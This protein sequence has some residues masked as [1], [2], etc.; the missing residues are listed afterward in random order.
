MPNPSTLTASE[1]FGTNSYPANGDTCATAQRQSDGIGACPS[2]A[3]RAVGD[4]LPHRLTDSTPAQWD[5]LEARA[6]ACMRAQLVRYHLHGGMDNAA[7]YDRAR[8][9]WALIVMNR[10]RVTRGGC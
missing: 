10:E 6:V 9:S 3:T 4:V 2:K 5:A 8:N 1:Q 7:D